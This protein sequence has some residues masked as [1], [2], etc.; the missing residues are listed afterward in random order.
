MVRAGL[1]PGNPGSQ[2][3][4]PNQEATLPPG[5]S[6]SSGGRML[7]MVATLL[8]LSQAVSGIRPGKQ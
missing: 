4:R 1:E 5:K 3:K 2:G 8:V 6:I 7:C